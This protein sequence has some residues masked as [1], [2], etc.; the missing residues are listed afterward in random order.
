MK[1]E[2]VLIALDA[3]VRQRPG[4]EFGNYGE[5]VAYR[6]ESRR[7]T[8]QLHDYQALRD[9]LDWRTISA[10]Q[11]A[12]AFRAY[13]GRLTASER[14][15]GAVGLDYCTGKYWPT[16]YRAA[17]C[18]VLASVLWALK[19]EESNWIVKSLGIWMRSEFRQ[20]FGRHVY[21]RWLS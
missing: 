3:W 12:D 19:W 8:R 7:I 5:R 1:T 16:E 10:E 6:A 15:D 14:A 13:S 4:L 9:A 11:W 2:Q 17:A 21:G 20:Q 18:A